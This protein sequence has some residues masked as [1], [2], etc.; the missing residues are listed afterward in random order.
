[1]GKILF[2]CNPHMLNAAK[3]QRGNY[4]GLLAIL[5]SIVLE[6]WNDK[7]NNKISEQVQPYENNMT[8]M[9]ALFQQQLL[10]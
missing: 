3:A 9:K 1:M 7:C 2:Y 4:F 6:I 5:G 8:G 10:N